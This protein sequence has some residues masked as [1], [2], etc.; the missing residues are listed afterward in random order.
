MAQESS[1]EAFT[2][3]YWWGTQLRNKHR[4]GNPF[5]VISRQA[6]ES[7]DF[8]AAIIAATGISIFDKLAVI[9]WKNANLTEDRI[10]TFEQVLATMIDAEMADMPRP[11]VR[12]RNDYD[13]D[14]R[15]AA[16]AQA[17]DWDAGSTIFERGSGTLTLP[18][19][20]FADRVITSEVGRPQ[21]IDYVLPILTDYPAIDG[22]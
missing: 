18:G 19:E 7:G 3:A 13:P 10:R 2:T 12:I 4:M 6:E 1:P 16:A 9:E 14:R 20:A 8:N 5:P 15:L 17:S 21:L 22:A 11:V